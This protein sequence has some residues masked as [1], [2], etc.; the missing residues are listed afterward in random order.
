MYDLNGNL[1]YVDSSGNQ[2]QFTESGALITNSAFL[3]YTAVS[4]AGNFVIPINATYNLLNLNSTA[5][6]FTVTLPIIAAI[7]LQPLDR[8]Y[9]F[10]D[11]GGQAQ[12]NNITIQVAPG[13]GNLIKYNGGS[14]TSFVIASSNAGCLIYT[15]GVNWYVTAYNSLTYNSSQIVEFLTGST[16]SLD[17]G[18]QFYSNGDLTLD[19]LSTT[20]FNGAQTFGTTS[21]TT[22]VNGSF[23]TMNGSEVIST[24]GSIS[25]NVA[26]GIS[27]NAAGAINSTV[28]SGIVSN[29]FNGIESLVPGGI[30]PGIAAGIESNIANGIAIQV[31]Q[32][33]VATAAD[34]IQSNTPGGIVLAGG[35]TDWIG[36]SPARAIQ[37]RCSI[38]PYLQFLLS[39]GWVNDGLYYLGPAIINPAYVHLPELQNGC[40]LTSV[41]IQMFNGTGARTAPVT[42]AHFTL[43][44]Q[45]LADGTGTSL[46]NP[47]LV[48]SFTLGTATA[49]SSLYTNSNIVSMVTGSLSNN[50]IDI[51][52]NEYF[53]VLSDESGTHA[54]GNYYLSITLNYTITNIQPGF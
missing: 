11:V 8:F 29:A 17:A 31:A 23:I 49:P 45:A 21:A 52:N 10:N 51:V 37:K 39:S 40:T 26:N 38:M 50:V 28:A 18:T 25:V 2:I 15:D 22:F 19:T 47:G 48:G 6:P 33:L 24:G 44:G 27:A 12:G 53:L 3:S 30:H 4:V 35:S 32:G 20:E 16:L 9:F 46:L 34:A 1:Y 43:Y 54:V 7:T 42:P 13:S 41:S 36:I 14:S 5:A